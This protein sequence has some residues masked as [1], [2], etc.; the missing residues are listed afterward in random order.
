MPGKPR[1]RPT[2]RDLERRHRLK[3]DLPRSE[4]PTKPFRVKAGPAH[5]VIPPIMRMTRGREVKENREVNPNAVAILRRYHINETRYRP[6]E[7]GKGRCI[8]REVGE[9]TAPS[10]EDLIAHRNEIVGRARY[11]YVNTGKDA[12]KE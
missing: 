6:E 1:E 5:A 8:F 4:S 11:I 7:L 3:C 2:E 12:R 9:G 10:E